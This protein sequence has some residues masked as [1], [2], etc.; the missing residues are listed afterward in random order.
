[1]EKFGGDMED[2]AML[3]LDLYL[4]GVESLM[5][6]VSFAQR[7]RL[8]SSILWKSL[9]DYCLDSVLTDSRQSGDGSLFGSLLEA[10]ALSGGDL[11]NLIS[12]IPPEMAIEGLRPRLV[13]AV[14]DY[15]LKVE[16]G[17]TAAKIS[18]NDRRSLLREAECRS[19]RG[20]RVEAG[21]KLLVV[22]NTAQETFPHTSAAVE[23][24]IQST[25][26]QRK[27]LSSPKDHH[28]FSLSLAIH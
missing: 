20:K 1:M 13:A 16:I 14:T 23:P 6:A 3:I 5:L 27:P 15:R 19:R 21:T 26:F 2:E 9:I 24:P 8:Y 17:A 18:D 4:K 22:S 12:Q 10:A 28:R 25:T 7:S 11:A